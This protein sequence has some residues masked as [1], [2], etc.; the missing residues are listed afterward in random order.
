MEIL[1]ISHKYPPTIG[2]MEKQCY[3]LVSHAEQHHT[4][5]KLVHDHQQENKLVFFMKIKNRVKHILKLNPQIDIIHLND[6]LMGLFLLWLKNYTSIPVVLTFH[7]LDLVFPNRWY[8]KIISK[9]YT[10]YDAA[11]AVSSA[12]AAA[13]I[14]RGF[15]AENVFVV[16]N[17]VDH[18]IAKFQSAGEKFIAK[19]EA[20]QQTS[21]ADKKVIA[22]LGRP[23]QRKGFSWF[24]RTVLPQLE[25]DVLV[26]MVGPITPKK[27]KPL[28][29][30]LLPNSISAQIELASGGMSDEAAI[31]R[32]L[33]DPTIGKRVLQTGKLPFNEV[34]EIL[35][36]AK[37]FV[38]P[39]IKKAGDAEGFGLVALEASLRQTIVLAS[40]LEGIPEAIQ[41]G[42]N[43]FLLPSRSTKDWVE[44]I[45]EL[46][47]S[48]RR[49][50]H[51]AIDFKNFTLENYGWEKMTEGYLDVFDELINTEN[52]AEIMPEFSK[53][54]R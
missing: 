24:L 23:V 7:G 34:L 17:G 40:D 3:E 13:C 16:P 37:L 21:I 32:L 2:G 52:S 44:K 14:K 12:T 28:W 26:I 38:M 49:M 41:D 20:S 46:L 4:V 11:I 1:F 50:E 36:L 25:E 54:L 29:K 22:M 51:L 18:E 43:G 35:G 33:E 42:K 8:Q 9:K 10:Q 45:N 39:N 31:E 30:K 15:K 19:F 48:N 53:V 27:E 6:G 5:H 47:K